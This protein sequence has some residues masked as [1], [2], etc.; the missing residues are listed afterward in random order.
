[1]N[2]RLTHLSI[3]ARHCA[4]IMLVLG[5][6]LPANAVGADEPDR[7]DTVAGT[8]SK[9]QPAPDPKG[10]SQAPV[11]P[12][13]KVP[14]PAAQSDLL[15]VN[16]FRLANTDIAWGGSGAV[17]SDHASSRKGGRCLFRYRFDVRNAGKAPAGATKSRVHLDKPNGPVLV[18]SPLPALAPGAQ[19]S[20]SGLVPLKVGTWTLYVHADDPDVVPEADD[21]NNLRRVRVTVTGDCGR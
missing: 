2:S 4:A 18:Q 8:P 1:M 19:N 10:P 20:A 5:I 13:L 17:S 3:T 16:A 12:G 21:K 9:P 7:D 11:R 6:A 15:L 14:G